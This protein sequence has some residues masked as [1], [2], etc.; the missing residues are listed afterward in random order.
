M[1]MYVYYFRM[2]YIDYTDPYD[3]EYACFMLSKPP[4][5]PQWQAITHPLHL[6]TWL[7]VFAAFITVTIVLAGMTR[8]DWN[9]DPHFQVAHCKILSMHINQSFSF[10]Q[11]QILCLEP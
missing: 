11:L 9:E 7:A 2:K 1:K 6:Y 8:G 10:L 5:I 3:I 4:P